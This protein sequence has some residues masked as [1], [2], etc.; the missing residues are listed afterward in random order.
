[1]LTGQNIVFSKNSFSTIKI[2][3]WE[4]FCIWNCSKY[5]RQIDSIYRHIII[6][7]RYT[8]RF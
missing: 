7:E 4:K 3:P 8:D 1:M 6:M 5:F 2:I